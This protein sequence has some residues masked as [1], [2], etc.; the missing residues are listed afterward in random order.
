MKCVLILVGKTTDR[1]L[2]DGVTKYLERIN[3]YLNFEPLIIS[4]LKNAKSLTFEQ[5]KEQEG[6]AILKILSPSDDVILLDEKG[7]SY[8]SEEFASWMEKKMVEST[9]RLV[10]VI[11]GPYGFSSKVYER[12][13]QK[14]S[15]SKMTFSH[16]MIRLLFVEQMYR[17]MTILKGEPYH[18]I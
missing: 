3:H 6:I 5:Q 9:K 13:T 10:F 8:T 12:A 14:L 4:E 18:H 7:Q 15:L 2:V 16:Q 17:A 1:Y 11:G